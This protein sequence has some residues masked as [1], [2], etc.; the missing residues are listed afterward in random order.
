MK[1]IHI[2]PKEEQ[3]T[4]TDECLGYLTK[5]CK[6]IEEAAERLYPSSIHDFTDGGFDS[7]EERRIIFIEGAKW[8]AERSYSEEDMKKAYEHG[9]FAIIEHGHG[10]TF[11]EWLNKFKKK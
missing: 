11:E 1:N 3:C 4:C 2:L 9:M 5:D 10:D 6:R 8:Q 7:S